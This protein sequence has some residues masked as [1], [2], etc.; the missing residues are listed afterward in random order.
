M[1]RH[2]KSAARDNAPSVSQNPDAYTVAPITSAAKRKYSVELVYIGWCLIVVLA[3]F[4]VSQF[5]SPPQT[6]ASFSGRTEHLSYNPVLGI[7]DSVRLGRVAVE[8]APSED[9]VSVREAKCHNDAVLSGNIANLAFDRYPDESG[10]LYIT[11]QSEEQLVLSSEQQSQGMP[12]DADPIIKIVS[13][14]DCST[15]R[16]ARI[17]FE[18]PA[19]IGAETDVTEGKLISGE[20]QMF[21]R[22]EPG[23]LSRLTNIL[24]PPKRTLLYPVSSKVA[25]PAGSRIGAQFDPAQDNESSSKWIGILEVDLTDKASGFDVRFQTNDPDLFIWNRATNSVEPEQISISWTAR[26]AGD[27]YL[28]WLAILMTVILAILGIIANRIPETNEK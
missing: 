3:V 25:I 1:R 9:K 18:G 23:I 4:L 21:G 17:A 27:P 2:R 6:L 15:Q 19:I 13:S 16:P 24:S 22:A 10:S 5:I 26:L 14:G 20:L 7:G 11:V 28:Q 12:L 8:S